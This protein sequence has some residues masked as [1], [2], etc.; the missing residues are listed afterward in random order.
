MYSDYDANMVVVQSPVKNMGQSTE[1][2]QDVL[3]ATTGKRAPGFT[4]VADPAGYTRE[5]DRHQVPYRCR[6]RESR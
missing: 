6:P 1:R 3:D 5:Q 2:S 4:T